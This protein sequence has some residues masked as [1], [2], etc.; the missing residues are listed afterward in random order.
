[1]N[2]GMEILLEQA[3]K[4]Q[5]LGAL[6]TEVERDWRAQMHAW[7]ETEVARRQAL[8]A[9]QLAAKDYEVA[10]E[11]LFLALRLQQDVVA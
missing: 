6:A 10:R 7:G 8:L 2:R 9:Q 4:Y 5:G 3:C 11:L 1:M